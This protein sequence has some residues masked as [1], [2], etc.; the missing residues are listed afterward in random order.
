MKSK[1]SFAALAVT[2]TMLAMPGTASAH[3]RKDMQRFDREVH[4]AMVGVV[5]WMHRDHCADVAKRWH[6]WVGRMHRHRMK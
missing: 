2:V 3:M 5:S 6:R 4:S 1:L